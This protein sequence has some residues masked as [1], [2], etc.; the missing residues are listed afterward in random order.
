MRFGEM[1]DKSS[2]LEMD[3]NASLKLVSIVQK[4]ENTSTIFS[5]GQRVEVMSLTTSYHYAQRVIYGF[6]NTQPSRER[7]DGLLPATV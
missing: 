2:L 5:E 3:F 1:L 4:T 6:T 7:G